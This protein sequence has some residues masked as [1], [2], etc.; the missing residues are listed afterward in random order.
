MVGRHQSGVIYGA[1]L[2][3]MML[4]AREGVVGLATKILGRIGE[5]MKFVAKESNQPGEENQ[6]RVHRVG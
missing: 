6:A 2:V 1:A 3:V 4:V 5:R